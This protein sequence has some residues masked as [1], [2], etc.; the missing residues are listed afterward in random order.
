MTTKELL[1]SD[2]S[3]NILLIGNPGAGKTTLSKKLAEKMPDHRLIHTDEYMPYKEGLYDVLDE[4]K[5]TEGN[6]IIEGVNGTR[7]LRKGLQQKS[8]NPDYVIHLRTLE[9]NVEKTYKNE[10]DPNKLKY[11]KGGNVA[12]SNI[13]KEYRGMYNPKPPVF[14]E[15]FN[16]Y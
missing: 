3:G 16:D 14:L 11:L 10:R 15:V 2:I 4:I 7:L 5:A 9:K 13:L 6:T 8:Y 1:E 12:N